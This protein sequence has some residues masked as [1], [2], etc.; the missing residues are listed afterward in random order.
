M[1][2]N[3]LGGKVRGTREP[4]DAPKFPR[5]APFELILPGGAP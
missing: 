4:S 1:R 3:A 2:P 5:S